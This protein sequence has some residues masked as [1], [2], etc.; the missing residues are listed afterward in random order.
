MRTVKVPLAGRALPRWSSVLA[1]FVLV[2]ACVSPRAVPQLWGLWNPSR[3]DHPVHAADGQGNPRSHEP[4]GPHETNPPFQKRALYIYTQAGGHPW[5]L[6]TTVEFTSEERTI[7]RSHKTLPAPTQNVK[8]VVVNLPPGLLGD[9]L[10]VPRCPLSQVLGRARRARRT[11]RW[12][13]TGSFFGDTNVGSDRE[14]DAG[15]RPVGGVR[16]GKQWGS[17]SC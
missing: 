4:Q 2:F 12:V 5:A 8:D 15:S 9:P 14:P 3:S 11:R 16:A 10:A 1:A 7:R 13:S 17:P 6:A